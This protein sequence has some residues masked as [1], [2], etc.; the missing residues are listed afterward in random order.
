MPSIVVPSAFSCSMR[1]RTLSFD[2]LSSEAVG[3]SSSSRRGRLIMAAAMLRRSF[4]PPENV[5]GYSSHRPSSRSKWRSMRSV[6][7]SARERSSA[8]YASN[9]LFSTMS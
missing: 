5:R 1:E 8:P 9:A 4:S 2:A 3:S 6:S 7:S